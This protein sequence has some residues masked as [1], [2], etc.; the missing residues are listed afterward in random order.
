[1]IARILLALLF[2]GFGM[3]FTMSASAQP[4]PPEVP[5]SINP[6]AGTALVRMV[7]AS[8]SQ[9]Y[10][11]GTGADGKAAWTLKAPDA[12]LRDNN[13]K[14]VGH[15]SAGPSWRYDDGSEITGK[16]AARA[17]AP[18]AKDIPWLLLNVVDHKGEG[19]LSHVTA[20]QRVN[21]KGG[22]PPASGCDSSH[23]N[24]EVKV[25]YTADYYFYGP[26]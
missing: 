14:V 22:Q 21:T 9:I 17:D 16:A 15:H 6:P 3:G 12:E 19:T 7:H 10:T 11:C 26:K 13:G 25:P 8:G 5:A 1:M 4:A 18:D 23:A 2:I 20:V 24:A